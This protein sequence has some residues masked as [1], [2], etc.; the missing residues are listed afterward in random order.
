[1]AKEDRT[2]NRKT[3]ILKR[4]QRIPELGYYYIVTDTKETEQNY[5]YGLRDSIPD[6]IRNK[7]VIKVVKT[8]T[9]D[10]LERS[11]EM[12]SLDPQYRNPWIVFDRDQ[13]KDFDLIIER[14]KG[15]GISV[16]WSNP[17]IEIWFCAYFDVMP[18]YTNSVQ[19][20]NGFETIFEKKTGKKYLKSDK[21]IYK[22]LCKYGNE[23]KAIKLAKKK[24]TE[25]LKDYKTRPSE[26]FPCTLLQNLIEEIKKK[27]QII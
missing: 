21:D 26:M 3:R 24:H 12:F 13:V 16:G 19:C 11:M 17:C 9:V 8:S 22:K 20:N 25:M 18:T 5:L 14:A 7:I 27:G 10:L 1:M 15:F 6:E 23:E 2:G 4:E